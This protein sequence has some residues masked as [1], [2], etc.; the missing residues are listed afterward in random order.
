MK[1]APEARDMSKFDGGCDLSLLKE[2]PALDAKQTP[3]LKECSEEAWR[4]PNMLL[5]EK[6]ARPL[7]IYHTHPSTS[8][9]LRRRRVIVRCLGLFCVR[10]GRLLRPT[11]HGGK[12]LF[13]KIC[14]ACRPHCC[15]TGAANR[16]TSILIMFAPVGSFAGMVS[17]MCFLLEGCRVRRN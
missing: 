15:N 13:A 17:I 3:F 14:S 9:P 16:V 7:N 2:M 1:I 10:T 4:R 8:C 12:R 5:E 6:G 11:L